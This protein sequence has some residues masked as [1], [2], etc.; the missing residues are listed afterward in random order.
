MKKEQIV[1]MIGEAPDEYVKDA[2]ESGKKRRIPR[3]SKWMGGIAAVLA[4]V[5]LVNNMPG[6]PLA[7]H[8]DLLAVNL[9]SGVL[10]LHKFCQ[11][12]AEMSAFGQCVEH[13]NL[14]PL[15]GRNTR[16]SQTRDL[17]FAHTTRV[18][19]FQNIFKSK[20]GKA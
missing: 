3:W 1:D 4:I 7:I 18:A 10:F 2:K 20:N 14:L 19:Y 17:R 16:G 13:R 9:G 15:N 12:H 11:R 8:A 5:L 6:I